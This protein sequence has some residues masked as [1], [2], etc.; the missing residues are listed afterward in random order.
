[1]MDRR[2]FLVRDIPAATIGLAAAWKSSF[3]ATSNWRQT[4]EF[5]LL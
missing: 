2:T 1:M 3:A 5:F 4:H